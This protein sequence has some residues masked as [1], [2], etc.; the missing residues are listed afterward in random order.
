MSTR[1]HSIISQVIAIFILTAV[2]ASNL[3]F[4]V[5]NIFSGYYNTRVG[6]DTNC[7]R[8]TDTVRLGDF[9]Y[10]NI[11]QQISK[12]GADAVNTLSLI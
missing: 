8:R 5:L 10:Q 11:A 2:G 3:S 7:Y 1:L 9:P 6:N 12:E 4:P